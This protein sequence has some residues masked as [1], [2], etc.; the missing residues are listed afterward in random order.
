MQRI[1]FGRL[2]LWASLVAFILG[3]PALAQN[4]TGT[5]VGHVTDSSGAV[6]P[7]A[8]VTVTNV[9]TG[10]A[11]ILTTNEAGDYTAPLL[12]PGNYRVTVSAA[13]F[14]KE[15]TSG[16]VLNADQTAR[17]ETAL[18]VGG[19]TETVNVASDAL[20][21]DTDTG[22]VGDL[23][24]NVQIAELPLNGRNFQDLLFLTPGAVNN[25][26]GEQSSYRLT[27]S[28]SGTSS[29]SLG[30]SRGSSEGYTVDGTSVLDVGY[31]T[32]AFGLSLD[33]IAEFNVL[34]KS[35]S[36]AYGF[37]MNQVNITSKSGTNNYHGTV[38]EF[39]RNSAVDAPF[40][41]YNPTSGGLPLLQQNQFGYA[42][43]GPVIIPH[44]YNG[45]NKTFFFANYEGFRQN[46]GGQAAP[47]SV[48][49]ADE[50][51]AKF[52]ASVLGNFTTAQLGGAS[53]T[54]TQCGHTYHVGDPHPL[55]NPFDPSGCPFPAATDGSYTI[56]T[57]SISQLGKL[58]MRPGLYYPAG[59][60]TTGPSIGVQNYL[61]PSKNIFDFDQQNYRID[62]TIGAKDLV[63]VHVVLHGESEAGTSYSPINATSTIQPGRLY[64][65]T[66]THTFSP[67]FTNQLRIGYTHAKW[68]EA[69]QATITPTDL[70]S[71]NWPNPFTAPGQNY[72]RIEFDAS[73]LNDGLLYGG[74]GA[75]AGA[76]SSRINEIWDFGDAV[77]LIKN[78]HT[79]TIGFAGRKIRY[80][81]VNGAGLGRVNYNGQYSGDV[82]ADALLGAG[83]SVALTELGPLS[84]P[85][86]SP[87]AHVHLNR[88][89]PY[90]QDDWKVT[91]NLTLNLG[92]R[93]EFIA[94]P[95]EEQNSFIWPDFNAPGGALYI[96][97][98]K[99]AA[100]YGGVNPF[101]P[102][103]GLYV[104]SLNGMRG[105]GPAQKDV[106]APRFGFAYRL[107]GDGKTVVRGGVGKYFD[108][109]EADEYQASSVGIY[110]SSSGVNSG[111][112]A[113]LSYPA[114][115]N[116]NAL[117]AAASTG[118]LVSLATNPSTSTLGFIQ[119]Q[120]G[121]TLNPYYWAWNFGVERELPWALKL[122]TDY[123]GNHGNHLFS[124]SNPNAPTQCIAPLGCTVTANTPATVPVA[125]RTP[126]QNLGTLVYAGF[127][128]FA[129]YNALNIQVE[130]RAS[131]LDMIVA[132]TWSKALDT[133]S[134][135]AGFSGDD[136][137]WAGPQNGHDV[138]ADYARG[139]FDVGQRLAISAV[140]SLPI[141]KGKAVL[142][143]SSSLADQFIGGWKLGLISSLQGGLPFTIAATDIQGANATYSE[144][145]NLNPT[146]GGFHKTNRQ[147][148]VY[149]STPGSTDQQFTQPAPG[150]FGDSARDVIRM[151]GQVNADISLAK[152]FPIREAANFEFRFDAFNVMNHWNPGQPSNL[153]EAANKALYDGYISPTD[154]QNSAR[155]LQISGRIS[156]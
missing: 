153:Q 75:F 70:N 119:I 99:T 134:A 56:P 52:D 146:P 105:P 47:A 78:R 120:P 126:Y 16:I 54:L 107:F 118:P 140:Y 57:G 62:Q 42:L 92:L 91:S 58:V 5:L 64:T 23:I 29:V 19:T 30:G 130:R 112:D 13:A 28:G 113:P 138:A 73:N 38:F 102:S 149:D 87:S 96:A 86:V 31:D 93:Y 84:N 122:E 143:N 72:P 21:L 34:T 51:N 129:N 6:I 68:S 145:A 14:N 137:G 131:P 7:N 43:G 124:R 18:K 27:I 15:T 80:N 63:F 115:F 35:Y 133:K 79:L 95:F 135:V 144:R 44:L 37:S 59:P 141:G 46:T 76:I 83:A 132:Y 125:A 22:A 50:M 17:V 74:G 45:R 2:A 94:T 26:G 117:P 103:T 82:F 11:K 67:N 89:A 114:A 121:H 150:Y 136:A 104:P 8:N 49:L 147:W 53:A 61:Y 25:P 32:P 81:M 55:F 48:P 156:F 20:N 106:F 148:Y 151:P 41:G 109:I 139:N 154:T 9:D 90:V 127:D 108:T 12:K 123:V 66:E 60:N 77:T 116:T 110:P 4:A 3:L 24:S 97:N 152:N 100:E 39:L 36:A 128:G 10:E 69:P 85:E 88:W 71:L 142:G 65:T 111:T 40:H 1:K 155:I 33:D 101:A 98:H